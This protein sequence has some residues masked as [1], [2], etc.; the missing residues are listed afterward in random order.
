MKASFSLLTPS[1]CECRRA[2]AVAFEKDRRFI[3]ILDDCLA[4]NN[5]IFEYPY[6]S[7]LARAYDVE[8]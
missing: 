2:L 1:K 3:S 6:S 7:P 8:P 5:M 4:E